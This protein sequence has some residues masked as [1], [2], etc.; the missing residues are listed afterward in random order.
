MRNLFVFIFRYHAFFFFLVLE[1]IC[2]GLM[3]QN[4]GYQRAAYLNI[5]DELVGRTYTAYNEVTDYLRLG[6]ENKKLADENSRI[7]NMLPS[8]FYLDTS[9]TFLKR[10]SSGRHLY[11]YIPARVIQTSTNQ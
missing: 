6:E 1:V 7:R 2:I 8:S 5:T 4:N 10:D 9:S 3:I 11:N